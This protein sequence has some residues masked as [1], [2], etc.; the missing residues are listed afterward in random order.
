[1]GE[2]TAQ[3]LAYAAL[4]MAAVYDLTRDPATLDDLDR[5]HR[6]LMSHFDADRGEMRWT[7]KGPESGKRELVAQTA[8]RSTRTWCS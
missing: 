1:M 5:L 2:R 7:L 6:H 3:D 8:T 4:A